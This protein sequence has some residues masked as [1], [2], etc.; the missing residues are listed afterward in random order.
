MK[1]STQAFAETVVPPVACERCSQAMACDER[2][3]AFEENEPTLVPSVRR[4]LHA[5]IR[6]GKSFEL[7]FECAVL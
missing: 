7:V 1:N 4:V 2:M 6:I 3:L 5:A